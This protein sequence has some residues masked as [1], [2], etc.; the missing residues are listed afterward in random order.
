[1]VLVSYSDSEEEVN[2]GNDNISA[3][4]AVCH[5]VVSHPPRKRLK[6]SKTNTTKDRDPPP[7][8][9]DFHNLYSSSVRVSTSDDPSL[10]GG[11]KRV[12]PHVQGNWP[13]HVYLEWFPDPAQQK[14]IDNLLLAVSKQSG[15]LDHSPDTK[16][17][18]NSLLETP[19]GVPLP[20]HISLSAP[21]VLRTEIKEAYLDALTDALQPLAKQFRNGITV[22]PDDLSWHLNENGSRRFLVLRVLERTDPGDQGGRVSPGQGDPQ[23]RETAV[24]RLDGFQP[25]QA[26]ELNDVQVEAQKLDQKT[27]N[28]QACQ[29]RAKAHGDRANSTGLNSLLSTS[30]RT[31]KTFNQ[32]ELYVSRTTPTKRPLPR[33]SSHATLDNRGDF[34]GYF[35][36][37]IAWSLAEPGSCS[38]SED[39]HS[40]DVEHEASWNQEVRDALRAVES[41]RITFSE[42]KVRVGKDVTT[43]PFGIRRTAQRSLFG[44][45]AAVP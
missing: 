33:A 40:S 18:V 39:K 34:S 27:I 9:A 16:P 37:S 38:V 32:P 29:R 1:M 13:A 25:Q 20:L 23:G 31:A 14:C 22:S 2:A 7:L 3:L 11:R 28:S 36:I 45:G 24:Q 17:G 21:L 10:H 8:P 26:K 41:M 15:S 19:L 5:D 6:I 4:S 12:V 43:L 44:G 35:H 30:N 42:V